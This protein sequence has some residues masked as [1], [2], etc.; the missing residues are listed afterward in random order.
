[1]AKY[2][3]MNK[4]INYFKI[5]DNIIDIIGSE[6]STKYFLSKSY[7]IEL[8]LL[9]AE[10]E[11]DN[12]D[13]GIEDTYEGIKFYRPRRAAFS[14]FCNDLEENGSIKYIESSKKKSKKVIRLSEK[15]KEI[16]NQLK[17]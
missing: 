7:G 9:L 2:K 4:L 12:A 14:S 10:F 11:K 13:N 8:M 5:M 6:V 16:V 17:R 3:L 1:M 15:S